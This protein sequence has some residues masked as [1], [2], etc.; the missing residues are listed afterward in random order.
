MPYI[1]VVEWHKT[2]MLYALVCMYILAPIRVRLIGTHN[3]IS[4]IV[5]EVLIGWSLC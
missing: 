5:L 2:I 1:H 3:F 4:N